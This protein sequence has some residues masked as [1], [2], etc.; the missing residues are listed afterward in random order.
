MDFK[1]LIKKAKERENQLTPY[2]QSAYRNS[3]AVTTSPGDLV[4][5]LESTTQLVALH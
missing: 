5:W 2:E 3:P 1:T 4:R